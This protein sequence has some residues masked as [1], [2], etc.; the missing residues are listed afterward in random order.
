ML[1]RG[2]RDRLRIYCFVSFSEL[3]VNIINTMLRSKPKPK[4]MVSIVLVASIYAT[5]VFDKTVDFNTEIIH[6]RIEHIIL[7]VFY[8]IT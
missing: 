3:I 1:A 2:H 7:E 4:I 6:K 5:D 8:R